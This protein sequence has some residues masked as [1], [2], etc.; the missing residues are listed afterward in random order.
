MSVICLPDPNLVMTRWT[1]VCNMKPIYKDVNI[2]QLG[3][4]WDSLLLAIE[5]MI[6]QS[7]MPIARRIRIRAYIRPATVNIARA[8]RLSSN[9]NMKGTS[10]SLDI[11]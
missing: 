2:R 7:S 11:I 1:V 6:N 9:L 3:I 4:S 8:R 5:A 10:V